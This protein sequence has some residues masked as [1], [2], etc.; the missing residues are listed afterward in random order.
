[1]PGRIRQGDTARETDNGNNLTVLFSPTTTTAFVFSLKILSA[2]TDERAGKQSDS[3][4]A[5][6]KIKDSFPLFSFAL[7][8]GV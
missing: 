6:T 5:T 7:V 8:P 1:M 3:V 2:S 4:N